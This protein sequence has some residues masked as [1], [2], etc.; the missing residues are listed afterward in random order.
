MVESF[1]FLNL[2]FGTRC[3][4]TPDTPDSVPGVSGHIPGL[5]GFQEF[6]PASFSPIVSRLI[7]IA[8]SYV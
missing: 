7:L 3:P 5:S 6:Q 4:E 1:D 8:Q 2:G